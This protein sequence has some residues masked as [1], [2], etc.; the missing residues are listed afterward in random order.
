MRRSLRLLLPLCNAA[1]DVAL[2]FATV[3]VVDAYRLTMRHPWP[4]WDQRYARV[5]PDFLR[6]AD[7]PQMVAPLQAVN[8][9]TLPAAIGAGLLAE[10]LFA[11]GSLSWR[12]STPF[13]IRLVGLHLSL[14][15][16]F[17]YVIGCGLE[18]ARDRW[19][20]LTWWYVGVRLLTVPF[21]LTFRSYDGI[22][23]LFVM[24]FLAAWTVLA[25]AVALKGIRQVWLR[26]RSAAA[27]PR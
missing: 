2:L 9:G 12:V 27:S 21:S 5:D 22:W 6:T 11:N 4:L 16:V 17:W 13:D 1:I 15:A 18:S 25:V 14:A 8:Y 24:L 10:V 20:K 7:G 19:K 26:Y 3:H 23:S